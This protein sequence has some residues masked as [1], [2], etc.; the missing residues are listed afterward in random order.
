MSKIVLGIHGLGNKAPAPVLQRYWKKS[1]NEG[2]RIFG[3]PWRP[4][5]FKMVYWADLMHP[6]PYDPDEENRSSPR[7]DDEPYVPGITTKKH[8]TH[9]VR[10]KVAKFIAEHMNDLF[11]NGD[12]VV[13]FESLTDLMIRRYFSELAFYFGTECLTGRYAGIQAKCAI[14]NRL[15]REL[16]RNRDD[17]IL[18]I[19]HSMGSIIAYDVLTQ[20]EDLKI[21]TLVTI[22]SPLGFPVVF[23]KIL[24]EMKKAGTCLAKPCVPDSVQKEWI[25]L[26]DPEDMIAVHYCLDDFYGRNTCSIAVKDIPVSNTYECEGRKNPHKSYGYLNQGN[27]RS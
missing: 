24:A 7:Y 4:F 19:A 2:F 14:R 13:N 25:N 27:G 18:L 9:T 16:N 3:Y 20:S 10:T 26:F 17:K 5:R 8:K 11:L 1:L 22:G 21:D 23:G 15:V 12:M 6:V